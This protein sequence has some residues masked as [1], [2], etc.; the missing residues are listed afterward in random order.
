MQSSIQ[1][2]ILH[3]LFMKISQKQRQAGRKKLRVLYSFL[4]GDVVVLAGVVLSLRL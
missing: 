3:I 4:V 1:L 2:G